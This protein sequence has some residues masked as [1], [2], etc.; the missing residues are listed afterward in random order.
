M[1]L[2]AQRYTFR[3]CRLVTGQ[4]GPLLLLGFV[5][6]L[7][8]QRRGREGLAGAF[9]VLAAL[10]PALTLLFWLALLAWAMERRRCRLVLGGVVATLMLLGPGLLWKTIRTCWRTIT[11][12]R[13]HGARRPALAPVAPGAGHGMRAQRFGLASKFWLQFVPLVPGLALQAGVVLA[14]GIGTSLGLV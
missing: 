9:L 13:R 12:P 1:P 11:P 10:K 6:F 8:Y 5:G 4:L 3:W 2:P 7:H 14:A